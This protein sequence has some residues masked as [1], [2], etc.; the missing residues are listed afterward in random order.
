MSEEIENFKSSLIE[1][2]SEFFS[3]T[4]TPE[5]EKL[6]AD[7]YAILDSFPDEQKI[8][9]CVDQFIHGG[10]Y[11][12]T[13]FIPRGVFILG[14]LIKVPTTV[15]IHGDLLLSN[16]HNTAHSKG[17]CTF[18]GVPYRRCFMFALE[19]TYFT[20]HNATKAT[21]IEDAEKEFTDEWELL[22]TYKERHRK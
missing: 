19:D 1:N 20:T 13:L 4:V 12:R 22:T 8:N 10:V 5:T 17:F 21:T 6:C 2:P 9:P 11:T 7:I 16:G 15:I 18:K 14:A 3:G